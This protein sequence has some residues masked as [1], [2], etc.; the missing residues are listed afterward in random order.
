MISSNF[1]DPD[2]EQFDQ[3]GEFLCALKAYQDWTGDD[4]LLQTY[5]TKILA[6]IERQLQHRFR[7]ATT[8]MV[9]NRREFRER[10]FDDACELAY[11]T[12]VVLGLRAAAEMGSAL[13][14]E[15]QAERWRKEADRTLQSMLSDPATALVEDGH[16]IKRR[17]VNG[18]AA[19]LLPFWQGFQPDVPL[20][21][22]KNHR[23]YPDTTMALSIALGLVEPRSAIALKTLDELDPLWNARWDNGGYDRYHTSSQPDQPGPWPFA[24]CFVLRAQHEA[25]MY[26]RSWRTLEW[27]NTVQGG[28]AG[29]W[30]EEIP[31]VRSQEK[32]AGLVPWTSGEIALFIIHHWLGVRFEGGRVVLKSNLYPDDPPVAADLRFRDGR[33]RLEV[34]GSGPV[35]SARVN[36]RTVKPNS[37]GSVILP[38]DFTS[39]TVVLHTAGIGREHSRRRVRVQRRALPGLSWSRDAPALQ[40]TP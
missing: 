30:F 20:R 21:T 35:T 15:A 40:P 2:M 25:G 26:D 1:D 17:D 14:A 3:M 31:S 27:L 32:T 12:Y 37:D 16:L 23:L 34:D 38:A 5:R 24:A 8:G 18:K 11:Q 4:S 29:T 13:V 39:G 9:H 36:G 33:L 19:D 6:L 28:R 7:D 22:E 10:D